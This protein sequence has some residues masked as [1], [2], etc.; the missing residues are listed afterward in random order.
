[1]MIKVKKIVAVVFDDKP[2]VFHFLFWEKVKSYYYFDFLVVLLV[3]VEE[4]EF[5]KVVMLLLLFLLLNEVKM[6]IFLF[7]V[8]VVV[9]LS[10]STMVEVD[11]ELTLTKRQIYSCLLVVVDDF[12]KMMKIYYDCYCS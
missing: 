12:L 9:V 8:V 10:S 11:V 1:M 7:L 2:F 6:L 3:V 4:E 5:Y